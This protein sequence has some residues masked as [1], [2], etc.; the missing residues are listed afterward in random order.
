MYEGN[1]IKFVVLRNMSPTSQH[2]I[3]VG[4]LSRRETLIVHLWLDEE[5]MPL[6]VFVFH[7]IMYSQLGPSRYLILRIPN[8]VEPAL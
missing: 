2:L 1:V 3:N 7:S 5:I 6:Y 8:T 4:R